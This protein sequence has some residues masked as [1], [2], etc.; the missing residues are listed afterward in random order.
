MNRTAENVYK[1]VSNDSE[2][3][4]GIDDESSGVAD[5]APAAAAAADAFGRMVLSISKYCEQ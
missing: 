4:A 5:D 1:Q 3:K 2:A